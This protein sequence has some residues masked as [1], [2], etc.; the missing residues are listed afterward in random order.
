MADT[1]IVHFIGDDGATAMCGVSYNFIND[2]IEGQALTSSA[3]HVTCGQCV[4]LVI[5]FIDRIR[6]T[7]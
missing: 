6:A 5:E 7:K 1:K 3:K 2:H 4:D